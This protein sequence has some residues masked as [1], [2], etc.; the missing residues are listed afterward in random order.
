MPLIISPVGI[1]NLTPRISRADNMPNLES[2]GECPGGLPGNCC[3]CRLTLGAC[4]LGPGLS[5]RY[6]QTK[7]SSQAAGVK[8]PEKKLRLYP[9]NLAYPTR[10]PNFVPEGCGGFVSKPKNLNEL[11]KPN[12]E[13]GPNVSPPNFKDHRCA[14]LDP[15]PIQARHAPGICQSLS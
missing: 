12:S 9:M 10:V 6:R 7:K 13:K 4:G 15:T 14:C 11:T 5:N 2:N 8:Y 1:A 3:Y